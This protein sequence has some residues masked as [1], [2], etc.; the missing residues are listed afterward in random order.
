MD[1]D[2][3]YKAALDA[4]AEQVKRNVEKVLAE[5]GITHKV[6]QA[7]LGFKG[8]SGYWKMYSNGTLDLRKM[9]SIATA[10]TVAP[11]R[12]LMGTPID[13]QPS[14]STLAEPAVPYGSAVYIEQRIEWLERE[15]RKLKEQQRPK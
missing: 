10:L 1:V 3:A 12:I 11:E 13:Q 7:R 8:A 5:Q 6:L 15:V 14:M 2:V 4:V 9:V